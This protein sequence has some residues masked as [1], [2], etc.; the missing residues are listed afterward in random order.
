MGLPTDDKYGSAYICIYA[1]S[2]HRRLAA[3]AAP[4]FSDTS[5]RITTGTDSKAAM[6]RP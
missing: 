5:C 4:F 1:S 3:K 6:N 2:K